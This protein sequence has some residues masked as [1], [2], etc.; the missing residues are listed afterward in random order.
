MNELLEQILQQEEDHQLI[1]DMLE[2]FLSD[3]I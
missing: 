3:E 2:R 1:V